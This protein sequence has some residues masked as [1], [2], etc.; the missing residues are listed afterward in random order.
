M[1]NQTFGYMIL[2]EG[3]GSPIFRIDVAK[4]Q[5]DKLTPLTGIFSDLWG[6]TLHL[7]QEFDYTR[8]DRLDGKRMAK[9]PLYEGEPAI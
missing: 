2:T 5:T 9:F 6:Y 7:R 4:R 8:T 3:V 1:K